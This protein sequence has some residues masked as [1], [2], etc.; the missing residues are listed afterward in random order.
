M[1]AGAYDF[2]TQD[3]VSDVGI[4]VRLDLPVGPLRLD[5]GF[6]LQKQWG[7]GGGGN[8]T[9]TSVTNFERKIGAC[10]L[11]TPIYLS[12]P[13]SM[14]KLSFVR[15]FAASRSYPSRALRRALKVGTI[16]M[17]R[18]FKEYNKTKDAESK[19]NDAK[20]AAKKEYDDRAD[21]YK[22]ALDEI[23][24]LNQQLEAPGAERGREDAKGQGARRE[25]REHQKH[26]ARDQ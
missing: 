21:S 12:D 18:A 20:N 17:N 7:T 9:S 16:D 10:S 22:K 26:G 23:N 3:V 25:N 11:T 6:P 5:Y 2:G 14:K 8:S 4:G 19:I 24:K 13:T 15:L 1:N